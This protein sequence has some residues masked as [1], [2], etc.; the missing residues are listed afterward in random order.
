MAS[1]GFAADLFRYRT[2]FR[3]EGSFREGIF[4]AAGFRDFFGLF[5]REFFATGFFAT[6]DFAFP[7][8]STL[9]TI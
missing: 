8:V 4:A 6:R 9:R 2:D 5:E 7:E 3:R 1:T